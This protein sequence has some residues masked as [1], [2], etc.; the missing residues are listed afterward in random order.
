MEFTTEVKEQVKELLRSGDRL[1]AITYLCRTLNITLEQ[2]QV[3]VAAA[4]KELADEPSGL[5]Y[6]PTH[7]QGELK[8]RVVDLLKQNKKIEAVKAVKEEL[9]I[10]LKQALH[11]VEEVEKEVN[12][13]FK[14]S[15][16]AGCGP[17]VFILVFVVV[18][19]IMMG[20]AGWIY[21]RK[22]QT[23]ANGTPVQGTVVSFNT[24]DD[25]D[26][27]APV[28]A[29]QWNG[30]EMQYHS[31]TYTNPPAYVMGEEVVLYIDPQDPGDVVIDSFSERWLAVVILGVMGFIFAVVGLIASR[32]ARK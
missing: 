11:Y 30:Q 29:Y 31:S 23:I 14:S 8:T 15:Q 12:P 21:T 6:Q 24:N 10:R 18:G 17:G 22:A 16:A 19:L 28:V 1:G 3:L 27:L 2:A 13:K 20:T 25:G 9:N 32:F 4:D 5:R 26:A 7:I